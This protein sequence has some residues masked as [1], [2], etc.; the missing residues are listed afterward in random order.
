MALQTLQT[1]F[2]LPTLP[3]FIAMRMDYLN[4]KLNFV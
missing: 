3:H 1:V 4:G 2:F